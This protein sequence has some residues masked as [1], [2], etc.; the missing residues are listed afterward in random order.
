VF[1]EHSQIPVFGNEE[2]ARMFLDWA[3][4]EDLIE[5]APMVCDCGNTFYYHGGEYR[6]EECGESVVGCWYDFAPTWDRENFGLSVWNDNGY[7]HALESVL[8][9]LEAAKKRKVTIPEQ[10]RPIAYRHAVY[11]GSWFTVIHQV[12]ELDQEN[13]QAGIV[14]SVIEE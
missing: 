10:E 5:S 2:H 7:D 14:K 11:C 4:D 13:E 8:R 3:I 12:D 1:F 6:C 9:A